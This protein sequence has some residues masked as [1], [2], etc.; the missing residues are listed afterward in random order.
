MVL[1]P[2]ACPAPRRADDAAVNLP[3]LPA[4]GSDVL[5]VQDGGDFA[6]GQFVLVPE[7]AGAGRTGLL[8]LL[9][10]QF[11]L[12]G[13]PAVRRGAVDVSALLLL[14]DAGLKEVVQQKGPLHA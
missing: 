5:G 12:V 9:I 8:R 11:V 14:C 4:P 3:A 7:L 2:Q 10:G 13:L 1:A 6:V